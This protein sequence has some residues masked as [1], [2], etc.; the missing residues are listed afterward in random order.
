MGV[1]LEVPY[2]GNVAMWQSGDMLRVM[3]SLSYHCSLP[4]RLRLSA[5]EITVLRQR[6]YGLFFFTS[7][8]GNA[9]TQSWLL[10]GR[11]PC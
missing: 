8:G 7:L 4:M 9:R 11:L 6:D 2:C 10:P 5:N 3:M 1:V